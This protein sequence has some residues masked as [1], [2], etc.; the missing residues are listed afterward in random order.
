M[1]EKKKATANSSKPGL[2]MFPSYLGTWSM[3]PNKS[4]SCEVEGGYGARLS[5]PLSM[6]LLLLYLLLISIFLDSREAGSWSIASML[7]VLAFRVGDMGVGIGDGVC[8]R[9]FDFDRECE[10]DDW[11]QFLPDQPSPPG[12]GGAR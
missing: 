12:E 6:W 10:R 4:W 3:D 1:K 8:E 2:T 11:W 9:D 5:R 7:T